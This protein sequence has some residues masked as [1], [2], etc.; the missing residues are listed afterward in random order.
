MNF[1]GVSC[2]EFQAG[3]LSQVIEAGVE[4]RQGVIQRMGRDSR[5]V[6]SRYVLLVR[7]LGLQSDD[8]P[9]IMVPL[10]LDQV[11]E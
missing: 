10:R 7:E 2:R 11:T 9:F 8:L 1:F 6:P 3:Q 4:P 5:C